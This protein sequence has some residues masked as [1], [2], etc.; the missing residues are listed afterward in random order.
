MKQFMKEAKKSV[1]DGDK[2]IKRLKRQWMHINQMED[3]MGDY[4]YIYEWYCKD[5]KVKAVYVGSTKNLKK[6]IMNHKDKLKNNKYKS[7]HQIKYKYVR[8]NGGFTNWEF[9]ILE[10][11]I[12]KTKEER[13]NRER[14]YYN[15]LNAE[16]NE[17]VPGRSLEE[18]C[19]EYR[20][21]HAQYYRDYSN[22]YYKRHKEKMIKQITDARKIRR[23]KEKQNKIIS[24]EFQ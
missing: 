21:I 10:K 18:G 12:F 1:K 16:L 20:K 11:T 8:A 9:K 7:Y 4:T 15:I 19:K 2:E 3:K 22:K 14:H 23:Q 6:R 17:N 24:L 13:F 5:P